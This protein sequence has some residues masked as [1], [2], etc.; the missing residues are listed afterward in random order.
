MTC[1]VCV[2]VIESAVKRLKGVEKVQVAL[3]ASKAEVSHYTG[4]EGATISAAEITKAIENVGFGAV[5]L[6][7]ESLDGGDS[8]GA[9]THS[10]HTAC[11]AHRL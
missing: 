9:G 5:L 4:A 6:Y 11:D 3:I 1:A 8:G 7:S 2:G 10:T